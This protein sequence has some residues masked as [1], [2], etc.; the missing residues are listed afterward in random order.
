MK[1]LILFLFLF[2]LCAAAQNKN[3]GYAYLQPSF[4]ISKNFDNKF[5]LN[6]GVGLCPGAPL[7]VGAGFDFFAFK[8][9]QSF[10][11]PKADVRAFI[12][13]LDKPTAV[14]VTLQPG[15]VIYTK[16]VSNSIKGGFAFDALLGVIARPGDGKAGVTIN[17]GYSLI[18]LKVFNMNVRHSGFKIQG[19]FAF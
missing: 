17:A 2:P 12:R 10:F 19:G 8:K 18:T 7:G 6:G 11:V 14:Y 5:H 16:S 15:Y 13:G 4:F 1:K 3:S 9:N